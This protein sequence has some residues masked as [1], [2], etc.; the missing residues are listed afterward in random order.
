MKKRDIILIGFIV[1]LL[2]IIPFTSAGFFND[3]W[4]KITGRVTSSPV[5]HNITVTSGSSPIVYDVM[6]ETMTDVSSGPTED[7]PTYVIINFSVS[8]GDGFGN[9]NDS[10]ATISFNFSGTS[11][12]NTSCARYEGSDNIANYTCNVTIWWFDAPGTWSINAS[13]SDTSSNYAENTTD[14]FYL[15]ATDGFESSPSELT[16]GSIAPGAIDVEPSEPILMNNTGNRERSIEVNATD[17]LGEENSAQALW[18]ANFSAHTATNCGGTTMVADTYTA[19]SGATLPVGN[20]TVGGGTGQ[21]EIFI[22]LEAAN[23]ILDAQ[24]YS[25]AARGTWMIKIVA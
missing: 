4:N 16:W 6:N 14:T 20:Y 5:T 10:T 21:E 2:L 3:T 9:L 17:L 12:T 13:I 11:R 24:A 1:V 8:D 25:T 19:V 15:G 7:S 22:C 23:A 18:A